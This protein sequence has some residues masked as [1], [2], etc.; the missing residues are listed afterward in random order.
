MSNKSHHSV[1]KQMRRFALLTE[2]FLLS[3]H[4]ARAKRCFEIAGKLLDNGS[5]EMKCA[6]SNVFVYSVS[7]FMQLHHFNIKTFFPR[8]LEAEYYKQA[9]CSGC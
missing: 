4:T 3:G 9:C 8:S 1:F 7:G 6:V 5:A 2:Q